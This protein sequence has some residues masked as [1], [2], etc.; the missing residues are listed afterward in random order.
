MVVAVVLWL[1]LTGF[2]EVPPV[3]LP[4]SGETTTQT[5]VEYCQTCH[6]CARTTEVCRVT[7]SVLIPHCHYT[8]HPVD[9]SEMAP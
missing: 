8:E 1:L 3:D 5:W 4:T 9:C 6:T 7:E 2:A